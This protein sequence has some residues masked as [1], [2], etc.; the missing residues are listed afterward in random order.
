MNNY[1]IALFAQALPFSLLGIL[2]AFLYRKS[3]LQAILAGVIGSISL[4][5]LSLFAGILGKPDVLVV[6]A[7]YG[8]LFGLVIAYVSK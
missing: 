2:G 1:L 5:L 8:V 3:R 4:P 7:F 6:S